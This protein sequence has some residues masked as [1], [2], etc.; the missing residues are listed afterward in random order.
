MVRVLEKFIVDGL[1]TMQPELDT[2]IASYKRHHKLID[3]VLQNTT[4]TYGSLQ[5][6]AGDA[7]LGI[8]RLW[9]YLRGLR[10]KTNKEFGVA[11]YSFLVVLSSLGLLLSFKIKMK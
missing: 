8:L 1:I 6:I 3:S 2:F 10:M 5:G 11:V 9:S 4:E 7:A